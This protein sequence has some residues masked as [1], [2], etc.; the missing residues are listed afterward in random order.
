[1]QRLLTTIAF[2]LFCIFL[3]A[4]SIPELEKQL[5]NASS[6][7][8]K[9]VLNLKLA[10]AHYKTNVDKAEKHAKD[11]HRLAG[12][13]AARQTP[14]AFL[15]GRIS[16]KQ[17]DKR[18][19]EVWFKSALK[20]AKIAN[21]GNYIIKSVE[22]LSKLA[23]RDY[24][25]AYQYTEEA[26]KYFS[27][28][29]RSVSDLESNYDL[30]EARL[31][32]E[33]R[34]L[35]KEKE[36]LERAISTLQR[37]RK[38]L[39]DNNTQLTENNRDL[40]EQKQKVEEE[41]AK[42][43]EK[44]EEQ[45]AEI[46]L[47][48]EERA[49][50]ELREEKRARMIEQLEAQ[51]KLDSLAIMEQEAKAEQIKQQGQF[52]NIL[53]GAISLFVLLLSMIF[54]WRYRTK[55]KAAKAL[56]EKNRLLDEERERS[57][58]LLLNILPASIANELK[59][60]GKAKAQK[61]EEAT[62]LFTDFKNFTKIAET[63]TPEKLV[64]ELDNCFKAFDFIISQ[65]KDDIEKIKTI[66]DAYMCA[67]GL[68]KKRGLPVNIIK[69]ALEMQ[70]FL[71]EQKAEK[72]AKGEP[73]FEARIGLHTGPVVAGVVGVNKFAYDIWGDTVNIAA[74]MEANCE[75]GKVNISETTYRKVKYQF[76]SNYR[77]KIAAKN[78]GEIDMYYVNQ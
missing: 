12:T 61:Y 48:S 47:M 66:G 16:L 10:D 53:L 37:D 1:M 76:Q 26:F 39:S 41:K 11:A 62:V 74:R 57:D 52:F 31:A 22:Q 13:N 30:V 2:L 64:E 46:T 59:Q 40:T 71:E 38:E 19:A 8:E 72:R 35:E 7:I 77:G 54:Y 49:K 33:R 70:Q 58:E 23:G 56:E 28:N 6:N 60:H 29:G 73:Y 42:I 50:S 5:R 17:R 69:A 21:D 63:L 34:K 9:S 44:V 67:S 75:P 36:D 25:K 65:Y 18:N 24:R 45:E 51:Q 3:S 27:E 4:Q 14:A 15:L 78:M 55:R 68:N 32:R 43:E 20:T